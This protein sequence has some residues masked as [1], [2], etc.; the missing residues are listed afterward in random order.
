MFLGILMDFDLKDRLKRNKRTTTLT[1][2]STSKKTKHK[3][4]LDSLSKLTMEVG[5]VVHINSSSS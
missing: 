3:K 1:S 5:T 2:N 4:N